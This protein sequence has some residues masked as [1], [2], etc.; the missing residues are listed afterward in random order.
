MLQLLVPGTGTSTDTTGSTVVV[1]VPG[2][3]V[4]RGTR[5]P[6]TWYKYSAPKYSY[7]SLYEYVLTLPPPQQTG[8]QP[9]LLF[10]VPRIGTSSAS[11]HRMHI[12]HGEEWELFLLRLF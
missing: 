2:S 5:V 7:M 9:N 12:F 4:L 6:G 11:S 3:L 10:T 1:P 8:A